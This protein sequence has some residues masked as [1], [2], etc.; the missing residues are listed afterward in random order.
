MLRFISLGSGSSGNCYLLCTSDDILM[1][2][3]GIDV[4]LLRQYFDCY[5]INADHIHNL[6]ITHDHI[7][8]IKAV[9]T[10]SNTWHVDVYATAKVHH[11]I[12][13]NKRLSA[14]VDAQHVRHIKHNNAF[15]L[16]AFTITPFA[17]PHDSHG[18][19]GYRI[20]H[21]DTVFALVTDVGHITPT[22]VKHLQGVQHLVVEANYDPQMLM[23]GRYPYF[24][25]QRITGP[26]GHLSNGETAQLI[27]QCISPA[28]EHLWLCHL[29]EENNLSELAVN[30]INESIAQMKVKKH[31][32]LHIIPLNRQKPTG[33]FEIKT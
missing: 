10:V 20:E 9:G 31:P 25:K 8:H 19:T 23:K 16:G 29:S 18:N 15:T 26:D 33:F 6:L 22:I 14:K 32:K 4:R 28:L 3:A 27:G 12:D 17:V 5:G 11:A 24:L 13:A 7:D 2:D 1:L 30:C 21:G